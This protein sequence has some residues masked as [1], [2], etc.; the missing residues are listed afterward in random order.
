MT[1]THTHAHTHA[2]SAAYRD[3]FGLS[4]IR[5]YPEGLAED[6]PSWTVQ[7][8]GANSDSDTRTL[9]EDLV[10]KCTGSRHYWK[11]KT[12]GAMKTQFVLR[13]TFGPHNSAEKHTVPA[14][15][16]LLCGSLVK[17][18]VSRSP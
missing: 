6:N 14:H 17:N 9:Q 3:G 10:P 13:L 8:V 11:K 16:V 5:L 12:Y 1:Q 18:P 2:S 7:I 4:L 15:A